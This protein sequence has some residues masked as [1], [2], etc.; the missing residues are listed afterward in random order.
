MTCN[1]TQQVDALDITRAALSG[2]RKYHFHGGE[3]SAELSGTA[4]GSC[5]IWG[6]RWNMARFLSVDEQTRKPNYGNEKECG[7]GI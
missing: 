3:C 4:G 2:I 5:E 7:D 1:V 6:T